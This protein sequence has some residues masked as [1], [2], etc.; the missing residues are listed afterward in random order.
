MKRWVKE[1]QQWWVKEIA[2]VC[3][4]SYC[5]T[6]IYTFKLLNCFAFVLLTTLIWIKDLKLCRPETFHPN[7]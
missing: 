1:I 7:S 3:D 6:F 2:F 4:S 5:Q